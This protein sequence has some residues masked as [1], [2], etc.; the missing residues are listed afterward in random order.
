VW[1]FV[2]AVT[3]GIVVAAALRTLAS[4]HPSRP[5]FISSAGA[6]EGNGEVRTWVGSNGDERGTPLDL[7]AVCRGG[8]S[9]NSPESVDQFLLPN[10]QA[11]D[12]PACCTVC[13]HAGSDTKIPEAA[14][15]RLEHSCGDC[16]NETGR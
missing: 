12:T 3:L 15:I 2:A 9:Q 4:G 5:R 6:G 8:K 7:P 16:H 11:L 10:R 13:H 1:Q 14:K